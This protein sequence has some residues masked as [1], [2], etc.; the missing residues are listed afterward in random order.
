MQSLAEE[1]T[2]LKHRYDSCF[3]LWFEGYL[4]P[5][6]DAAPPSPLPASLSPGGGGVG[7]GGALPLSGT[8]SSPTSSAG[9][10]SASASTLA[11]AP[12]P[13]RII[14]NWSS[15]FRRRAPLVL[16]SEGD[17][18][19]ASAGGAHDGAA[20]PTLVSVDTRGKTRAQIKAEEY[21]RSCGAAWNEYQGCLKTAIA[22]NENLSTLLEQARDDHPLH[23]MDG[24]Q[25]TAWDPN[26]TFDTSD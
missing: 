25:G 19:P 15:A 6:L 11:P 23:T 8:V 16:A 9:S 3:N 17:T 2:P 12:A 14:T 4:Q 5:A 26:G 24:L 22:K 10:A 1:C 13:A 7:A 21:E 20:A 18:A